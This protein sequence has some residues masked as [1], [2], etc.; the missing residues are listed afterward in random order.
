MS[1]AEWRTPD[2]ATSARESVREDAVGGVRAALPRARRSVSLLDHRAL[3]RHS[4]QTLAATRSYLRLGA[5]CERIGNM[6]RGLFTFAVFLTLASSASAGTIIGGLVGSGI[7]PKSV[8]FG[9]DGLT[10]VH[11]SIWT[12]KK[13][14]GTGTYAPGA[15]DCSTYPK[16]AHPRL[17][18]TYSYPAVLPCAKHGRQVATFTH[19]RLS[20]GGKYQLDAVNTG[21]CIWYITRKFG[22]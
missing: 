7:K 10:H 8:Y 15:A 13:A 18:I 1:V 6:K 21:V 17:K 19:A 12:N 22:V 5:G 4:W 9:N 20:D 16:C 3:H 14:V 2:H 11:W